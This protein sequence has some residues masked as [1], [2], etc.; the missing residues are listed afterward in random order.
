M[1]VSGILPSCLLCDDSGVD[2]G[3][4]DCARYLLL[5]EN[6]IGIT[7][8]LEELAHFLCFL[9]EDVEDYKDVAV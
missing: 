2:Y 6:W 9:G 5:R 4:T 8:C 3:W 7:A 1:S